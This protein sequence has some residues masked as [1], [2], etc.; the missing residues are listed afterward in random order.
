MKSAR[1]LLQVCEY[2]VPNINVKIRPTRTLRMCLKAG[3][4]FVAHLQKAGM[5]A[6]VLGRLSNRVGVLGVQRA[7]C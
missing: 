5:G 4:R 7:I 6:N 1:A 3:L 2:C